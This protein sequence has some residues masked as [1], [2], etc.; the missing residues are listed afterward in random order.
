MDT[1]LVSVILA[2]YN[3]S[4][5]LSQAI[6]SVLDQSLEN[7]ELFI[8]DD[9]STDVKVWEIIEKYKHQDSRIRSFRNEINKERSW[10]K[11]FGVQMTSGKYVAFL[12]DDDL[13][14]TT[15]LSKQLETIETSLGIGIVGTFAKFIDEVWKSLWETNHLKT[16]PVDI[17]NN[18]LFTNQFIHS[19]VLIRRE[20]FDNAGKFPVDMNL[21]EDYDL[22]FRVL[23]ISEGINI[24]ELL[25]KYRVRSASTT[26]KNIYRMKWYSLLLTWKY[27]S[28]FPRFWLAILVRLTL[29]PFNTVFLL[30][31][32]KKLFSK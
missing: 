29:F 3:G 14:E 31:I 12:D 19:S 16:S 30:S 7:F 4:D 13:W 26:A 10:S 21:C 20:V 23:R 2:T 25:V 27:R 22:W 1:P 15:K 8:V 18:I 32:W 5:Y 9:A 24:P 11:N 28:E 6:E 17:K